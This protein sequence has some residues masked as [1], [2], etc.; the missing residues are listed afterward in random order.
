MLL[1]LSADDRSSPPPV[2]Q[3]LGEAPISK[4]REDFLLKEI[5]KGEKI[6]LSSVGLTDTDE[7]A[8]I[9]W[10]IWLWTLS[11]DLG[12]HLCHVSHL[13]HNDSN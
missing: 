12:H 11:W 13:Y 1:P 2:E 10:N 7:L 5:I 4:D 3:S 8:S 6:I 9:S